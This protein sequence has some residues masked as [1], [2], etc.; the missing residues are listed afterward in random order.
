MF[1][2]DKKLFSS[3]KHFTM[4]QLII[5]CIFALVLSISGFSQQ[6]CVGNYWTEAQGKAHLD[7]VLQ[8][9]RD[10]SQWEVR[11]QIIR[12]Q[13][14]AGS[15][16][17]DLFK[18]RQDP[19]I[20]TGKVH[21]LEGYR[22]TNMAIESEPGSWITGNLYEPLGQKGPFAGILCPHGHWSDP[23]DY[24]RYRPDMQK[25]CA[26]LCRMGAVVFAYDMVGYGDN[27]Q[28]A[29]HEDPMA[30]QIQTRNSVRIVDY[31]T[32]RKDVDT[33]RI[34][35]TGASGGG[36]QSFILAAIDKRVAVSVPVVQVSAHF[37]G[38][39]VC[40]SGM[41]VHKNG[42]FQTNNVEI[43][44]L[45]APR[46]M[47][48]ISDGV[49]WT[50]NTPNVEFPFIQKIYQLYGRKD[51]VENAHFGTEGHDYG[52]TKRQAAYGFLA[53]YLSLRAD[54]DVL[55]ER[56]VRIFTMDDLRMVE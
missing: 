12:Q 11:A 32:S 35:V 39:C 10:K 52:F 1:D 13:I 41:P 22:V 25:R 50:K 16:L 43:A 42:S 36:T 33:E 19:A 47:L 49:D 18:H 53:K 4:K 9:V 14:L 29:G 51:R 37:F 56:W 48:L 21:E 26:V 8:Q 24:G 6:L 44:A 30:F 20:R 27:H 31:L 46:P 45:A 54:P 28:A 55:S 40:E 3:T 38:G 34:A 15:G 2:P 7:N 5:N 17:T 23:A